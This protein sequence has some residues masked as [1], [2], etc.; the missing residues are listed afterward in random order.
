M[1]K[2]ERR[3]RPTGG[4]VGL[5]PCHSPV[6][7][8]PDPCRH[9]VST[10]EIRAAVLDFRDRPNIGFLSCRQSVFGCA[11]YFGAAEFDHQFPF[12]G[13]GSDSGGGNFESAGLVDSCNPFSRHQSS[14]FCRYER[15]GFFGALLPN[16]R[17]LAV[18]ANLQ[19]Q[20]IRTT[21]CY[22]NAIGSRVEQMPKR[23]PQKG[24]D[25]Y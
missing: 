19:F 7:P 4:E 25:Q 20:R 1:T 11:R 21:L 17:A 8:I 2:S 3:E 14:S 12:Q 22:L 6:D 13:P 9:P 15:V 5:T 10:Q 16:R 24:P 23:E 18:S